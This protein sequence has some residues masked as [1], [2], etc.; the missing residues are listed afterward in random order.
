ME[1]T[2]TES[3]GLKFVALG[4]LGEI[5][6]NMAAFEY[7]DDIVIVDCGLMFPEPYMLGIDVVIPDIGYLVER[8]DRIRA[9]LLTHGHEDHIG[10]LPYVPIPP[11][12][13]RR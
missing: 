9:I 3:T 13:G 1:E 6:L 10:A 11:S 5:G 12:T 7:G 4:G 2:S 8:A